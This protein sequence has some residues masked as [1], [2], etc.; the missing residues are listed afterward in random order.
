MKHFL[1]LAILVFACV[2]SL[3]IMREH[4]Q[5]DIAGKIK[6]FEQ[7]IESMDIE[8]EQLETEMKQMQEKLPDHRRSL[9]MAEQQL[10]PAKEGYKAKLGQKK[11]EEI[12]N[13]GKRLTDCN[14]KATSLIQEKTDLEAKVR[15]VREDVDRLLKEIPPLKENRDLLKIQEDKFKKE[16]LLLVDEDEVLEKKDAEINM[17]LIKCNAR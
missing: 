16:Y 17:K 5:V 9:N 4:F 13:I 8:N 3:H 12:N 7:Q 2:F 10:G 1:Q 14:D 15:T 11:S 6:E